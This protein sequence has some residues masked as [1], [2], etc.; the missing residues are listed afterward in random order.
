MGKIKLAASLLE[1]EIV[2]RSI[3]ISQMELTAKLPLVACHLRV[4]TLVVCNYGVVQ[5]SC[6]PCNERPACQRLL[7]AW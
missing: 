7:C 6:F 1:T 4:S 3:S 5:C 2:G